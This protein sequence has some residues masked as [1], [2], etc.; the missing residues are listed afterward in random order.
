M[1]KG[2]LLKRVIPELREQYPEY[3]D[4]DIASMQEWPAGFDFRNQ[5]VEIELFK[6]KD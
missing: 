5:D 1:I 6:L 4:Q 2:E 3:S